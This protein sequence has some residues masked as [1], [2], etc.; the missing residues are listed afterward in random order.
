MSVLSDRYEQKSLGFAA[1]FYY[2]GVPVG[3]GVSLLIAGYLE[4]I[5]GWR[6]C[7]YL[8][9]FLGLA[10]GL[11]MVLVKD[12]P[13]KNIST[14]PESKSFMEIM[15]L[16]YKALTKYQNYGI[17]ETRHP[18]LINDRLNLIREVV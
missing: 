18:E 10:L 13:R 17:Q 11:L 6:G 12:S 8:L 16:L 7:F 2:L 5:I 15:S 1:G 9:G 4:P 14:K 3:V